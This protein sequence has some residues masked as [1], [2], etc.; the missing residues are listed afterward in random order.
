MI[1]YLKRDLFKLSCSPDYKARYVAE[2]LELQGRA[3]RLKALIDKYHVGTLDFTPTCPIDLLEQQLDV[4]EHY[5]SILI[6]RAI[7]EGVDFNDLSGYIKAPV[8]I[9]MLPKH[10]GDTCRVFTLSKYKFID[11]GWEFDLID[12]NMKFTFLHAEEGTVW[13]FDY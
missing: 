10:E 4:M 13:V 6:T 12:D 7:L 2:Y 3:E 5:I 8:A 9:R 11:R 1:N